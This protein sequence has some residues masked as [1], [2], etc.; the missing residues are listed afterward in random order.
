MT[1]ADLG[2]LADRLADGPLPAVQALRHGAE[3]ARGVGVLHETG[4]I[5]RDI[6]PSNVLFRSTADR[7]ER[8]LIADLG[9]S[10]AIE[11]ASGFTVAAGSPGYMAPEQAVPGHGIDHRLDVYGI[12]ATVYRALTGQVPE[13]DKQLSPSTLRQGL[14]DGTDAIMLRA[15]AADPERRWPTANALANALQG[16]A[17][18]ASAEDGDATV[19]QPHVADVHTRTGQ[20]REQLRLISRAAL[21][22]LS[23][24]TY[25]MTPPSRPRPALPI[26]QQ[27]PTPERAPSGPR[28]ST[29]SPPPTFRAPTSY[30]GPS[31]LP[32]KR[33]GARRW[34]LIAAAV[35]LVLGAG[36]VVM[37]KHEL[38]S[39]GQG[40]GSESSTD[41]PA[42]RR[43]DL[44][45]ST[46]IST[47]LCDGRYIVIV[48]S[49]MSEDTYAADVQRFLDEHPGAEYLHSPSTCTSLRPF[50]DD[51]TDI[52]A[53]YYGPFTTSQEACARK[54]ET[55]GDA[56]VRVLN[57]TTP[58]EDVVSCE[59]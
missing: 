38:A 24:D 3:I 7:G 30:P 6:K 8:L 44:G 42:Y 33:R 17:D 51:G 52:Y 21:A 35:V 59:G 22:P 14:P 25:P 2:S 20:S 27:P 31:P 54:A 5:H 57:N 29:S 16:L 58:P 32:S 56:F 19:R 34:L 13:N 45:I 39:L 49:A 26:R 46:P 9:L 1:Y 28:S 53:A 18:R 43:A 55:G 23:P 12:G 15:L 41:S 4:V 40:E 50:D 37:F 10:K 47:P 36:G 48:G 11:Y